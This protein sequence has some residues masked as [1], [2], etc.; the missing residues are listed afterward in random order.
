MKVCHVCGAHDGP[1]WRGSRYD[2]N[3]DY[4][5]REEFLEMQP[6]LSESLSETEPL[7]DSPYVYYRRGT[8]KAWVYRVLLEDFKVDCERAWTK[9]KAQTDKNQRKLVEKENQT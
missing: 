3:A 9:P 4:C 2:F 1:Y 8:A 6:E 7:V 5:R